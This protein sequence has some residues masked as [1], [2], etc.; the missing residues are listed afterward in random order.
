MDAGKQNE[1]FVFI[2]LG[3]TVRVFL[4]IS[5]LCVFDLGRLSSGAVSSWRMGCDCTGRYRFSDQ[6]PHSTHLS[7]V[8]AKGNRPDQRGYSL[9]E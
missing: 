3:G 9:N 2:D 7:A 8:Y 4:L 6:Y 5:Y 1:V